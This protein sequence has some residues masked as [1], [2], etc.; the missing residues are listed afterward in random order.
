MLEVEI[1]K[2][3]QEKVLRCVLMVRSWE[4][5][6]EE[7]GGRSLVRYTRNTA[8]HLAVG[9]V[10]RGRRGR[11][12]TRKLTRNDA[13]IASSESSGVMKY[14]VLGFETPPRLH[15]DLLRVLLNNDRLTLLNHVLLKLK[16]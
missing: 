6:M 10:A 15:G 2:V 16:V 3:V 5:N 9:S 8:P 14:S 4:S 7:A 1:K 11:E 13:A 12:Q